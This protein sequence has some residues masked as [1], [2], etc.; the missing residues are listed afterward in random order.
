MK[1]NKILNWFPKHKKTLLNTGLIVVCCGLIFWIY[2]T[3]ITYH[4]LQATKTEFASST[5]A[6]NNQIFRL[7]KIIRQRTKENENLTGLLSTEQKARLELENIKQNN[8]KQIDTLTKLTTIDP[9]LLKKYSKVYFLSENY[10]PP[11]LIDITASYLID[12]AKNVQ[13]LDKISPF[14]TNMMGDANKNNI[15]L[16]ILSGY[17]SFGYQKTLKSEY[18]VLYGAGTANQFSAEQGYSEHQLGS[19]VDFTTPDIVGAYLEFE[20]SASF[21]WLNENAYK[22]GFII[23]Y[24]KVNKFYQYEPWHWRFVGRELATYIHD[25]NKYFYELDQRVI[26]GYLIK[27]FD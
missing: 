16:R 6:F 3:Y 14:L 11:K 21:K 1:I 12:P 25:Q 22:Y 24:P 7:D 8:E 17:R 9:E 18:K 26:D 27:L 15:P 2:F 5:M 13:I 10:I 4:T 23:S 20:N 19:A